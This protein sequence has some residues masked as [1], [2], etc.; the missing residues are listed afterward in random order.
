[1]CL[2]ISCIFEVLTTF[3]LPKKHKSLVFL[4][5]VLFRFETDLGPDP[6]K[7]IT[8]RTMSYYISQES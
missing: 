1:M 2:F 7:F 4:L 8:H 5:P 3:S 6:E